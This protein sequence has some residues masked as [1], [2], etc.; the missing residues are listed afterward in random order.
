MKLRL[1]RT[2]PLTLTPGEL[3]LVAARQ[4]DGQR[5]NQFPVRLEQEADSGW[6]PVEFVNEFLTD[7][8]HDTREVRAEVQVPVYHEPAER[9]GGGSKTEGS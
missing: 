5:F 7:E 2:N 9:A 1:V 3:Y 6:E 4:L 8:N